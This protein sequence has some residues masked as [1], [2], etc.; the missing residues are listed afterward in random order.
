MAAPNRTIVELKSEMGKD[1]EF[2]QATPNRTIVELKYKVKFANMYS[3]LL[4]IEP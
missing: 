2:W 1:W 3:A 4:P